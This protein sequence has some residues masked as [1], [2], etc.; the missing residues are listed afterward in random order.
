MTGKGIRVG[1]HP[2][3]PKVR[4]LQE[5]AVAAGQRVKVRKEAFIGWAE[6]EP[7][8]SQGDGLPSDH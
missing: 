4:L 8:K 1:V 2:K 7:A 3:S 5:H 6:E